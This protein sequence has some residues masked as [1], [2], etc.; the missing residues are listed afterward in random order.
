MAINALERYRMARAR[1]WQWRLELS[2]VKKLGLVVRYGLFCR[3]ISSSQDSIT[4]DTGSYHRA[5]F[6]SASGRCPA[7]PMVEWG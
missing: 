4:V 7:W 2:W 1:A 6:R 5:D 3:S